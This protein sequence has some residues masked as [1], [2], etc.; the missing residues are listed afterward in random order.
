MDPVTFQVVGSPSTTPLM[1]KLS[2]NNLLFPVIDTDV[3]LDTPGV[4]API[5][6]TVD[7]SGIATYSS[8]TPLQPG[9]ETHVFF[10]HA[11]GITQFR[12]GGALFLTTDFGSEPNPPGLGS[13]NGTFGFTG[14]TVMPEP[15]SLALL[16]LAVGGLCVRLRRA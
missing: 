8:T 7:P 6:V 14:Y 16:A 4:N 10:I 3:R 13:P 2:V 5:T 9:Q 11:A 12:Q 1:W 15:G